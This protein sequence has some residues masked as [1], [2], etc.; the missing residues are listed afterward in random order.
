MLYKRRTVINRFG[1]E[2]VL[3]YDK[4]TNRIY[5][6]CEEVGIQNVDVDEILNIVITR[7]SKN[8]KTSDIDTLIASECIAKYAEHEDYYRLASAITVSNLHRSIFKTPHTFSSYV[9]TA[10]DHVDKHG[11]QFPLI[12]AKWKPFILEHGARI[13]AAIDYKRDYIIDYFGFQTLYKNNYL[14]VNS[15]GEVLETP[16]DLYMRVAIHCYHTMGIDAVIRAYDYLSQ[17]YY[18]HATPTLINAMTPCGQLAS[19]FL[20][21]HVEDSIEGMYGGEGKIGTLSKLALTSKRSGGIGIHLHKIRSN[22]MRVRTTNGKTS[23]LKPYLIVLDALGRHV[24]QGQTRPG[25]IAVYLTPIHPDFPVVMKMRRD[26]GA[27]E[28]Q[29][30][31]LFY[32]AWLPDL[33]MKRIQQAHDTSIP[34]EQR[35]L[36][37]WSMYDYDIYPELYDCYSD[38][39]ETR[40]LKYESEGKWTSQVPILNIWYEMLRTIRKTGMP[41]IMYADAVNEKSNQKNL[42]YIASSN[43][44]VHGDT[45]ILTKQGYVTIS[46]LENNYVDV[47]NGKEWSNVQV[48]KTGTNQELLEISTTSGKI[49][50]CTKYHKFIMGYDEDKSYNDAIRCDAMNLNVGDKL[51]TWVDNNNIKHIDSISEIKPVPGLHDT[52]CF[53]EPK[54]HAGVFNGI[55]TGQCSEIVEYSSPDETAVC[56]LA[57]ISLTKFATP[58]GFDHAKFHEVTKFVTRG[59]DCVIDENVYPT[60]CGKV[61][62]NR[63]RPIGMGVQGLADVFMILNQ[64]FDS[65]EAA[66]TNREIFAT[67]YHAAVESSNEIAIE[68]G[69]YETFH[70]SPMSQGLFQFDLWEKGD[71]KNNI[72]FTPSLRHDWDELRNRV[73]KTGIRNSLLI[74]LMPTAGTSQ[75]MENTECFE[76]IPNIIYRRETKSGTFI[77]FNKHFRKLLKDKGMYNVDVT[78]SILQNNGSVQH[79]TFLSQHEKNVF[80]TVWEIKQKVVIDQAADRGHYVCQAQSMNLYFETPDFAVLTGAYLYG[81]KKGLKNGSYYI[82]SRSSAKENLTIALTNAVDPQ[83]TNSSQQPIEECLN[84]S[85]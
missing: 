29:A 51:I 18:T 82:R 33:F 70:G 75:I 30:T 66:E 49:L 16:S 73:Q 27:P 65:P 52:F 45:Q 8:M 58:T 20:F 31:H 39:F 74:A 10:M 78:N 68:R 17:H 48:I 25:A 40:Y 63:H 1:Q 83:Q 76:A 59:L 62:N 50:K 19:C 42:G 56:N 37:M 11:R 57:S 7:M 32:A 72:V 53:T 2:E 64:P 4:I 15:Y 84:C 46:T 69:S 60:T 54:L 5:R 21:A 55:L 9:L 71:Q 26:E 41:Y 80:K 36:I 28:D 43:L 44:C 6:E 79:L 61:S 47:W 23:G 85:A 34:Q 12:D 3:S 38:E 14:R 24:D 35:S 67:M 81:W 77:V 13:N 22:G